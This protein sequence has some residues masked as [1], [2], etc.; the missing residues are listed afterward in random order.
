M[1]WQN[2][3][4][5]EAVEQ[6]DN[7]QNTLPSC[8]AGTCLPAFADVTEQIEALQTD[9]AA[10]LQ[11]PEAD[12]AALELMIQ[13][14]PYR[15]YVNGSVQ[16]TTLEKSTPHDQPCLRKGQVLPRHHMLRAG[17]FPQ[18]DTGPQRLYQAV[19]RIGCGRK[20]H[21]LPFLRQLYRPH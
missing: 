14:G 5:L 12:S 13:I 10:S 20:R 21:A 17:R 9:P 7:R 3:F 6:M 18:R 2:K 15:I 16:V 4:R 1:Y 11:N 19:L 8:A